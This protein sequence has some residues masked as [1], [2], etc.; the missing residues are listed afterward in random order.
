MT[1]RHNQTVFTNKAQ[2]RD[3][4]RCLRSCPVKAIRMHDQQ[5]EVVADLCIACGTCIRHCPQQAKD[6]R[7]DL[8][9]VIG[10]LAEP[11]PVAASIAPSFVAA[12]PGWKAKRLGSA[13]RQLG[14]AVVAETAIAAWHVAQATADHVKAHPERSHITTACPAAVRFVERYAPQLVECLTPVASPMIAHARMIKQA[15]PDARVVFIGPCVAKKDEAQRPEYAGLVD[16]VLTFEELGD[17]LERAGIDLRTL[18]ESRFDDEPGPVSRLFPLEGGALRT[19]GLIAD[20]TS[21]E[22][23]AAGGIEEFREALDL[24]ARADRPVV[25]EPLFCEQGCINGPAMGECATGLFQRRREVIGYAGQGAAGAPAPAPADVTG[26]VHRPEAA[27]ADPV[28]EEDVRNELERTGK[29]DPA[30]QLD[31]GACGYGSC[32]EKA[33]AVVRGMAEPEMCIPYMR[34]LAE[35]RTDRIIDTSPNGIVILDEHLNILSMNPAF[36]RMF[37]CSDGLLGKRINRLLDPAPFERLAGGETDRIEMP[38]RHDKYGLVCHQILYRLRDERQYV[39]IFV[40]ITR[41]QADKDKLDQ[42]RAQT[43]FQARELLEHQVAMAQQMARFL[44]ESTAKGEVLVDKLMELATEAAAAEGNADAPAAETA[45]EAPAG[46]R[47][48]WLWD[49]STWTR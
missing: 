6:Y 29:A 33:I 13:L 42:L 26:A 37:Q 14:F 20:L 22:V 19:G 40:N 46:R 41:S 11:A 5:A 24:V 21:A 35:R 16:A 43:V 32:R 2:C 3:C 18:E 34:R 15:R 39:G 12:L 45:A 38:G 1:D 8:D 9:R 31:C 44:G 28:S 47:K 36:R 10:M 17:W 48:N 25:L 23:I 49:T 4:Y 27:A 30:D 7:D